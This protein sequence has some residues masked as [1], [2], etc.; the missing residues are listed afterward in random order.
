LVVSNQ[1]AMRMSISSFHSGRGLIAARTPVYS[2]QSA[3]ARPSA[4]PVRFRLCDSMPRWLIPSLLP[5]SHTSR[6]LITIGAI[7]AGALDSRPQSPTH[8]S[9]P[10]SDPLA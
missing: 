8:T 2:N 6:I 1:N 10:P 5:R 3:H 9:V 4:G 7:A